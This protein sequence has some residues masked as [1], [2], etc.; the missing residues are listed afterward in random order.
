MPSNGKPVFGPERPPT[1]PASRPRDDLEDRVANSTSYAIG[2]S[3][4]SPDTPAIDTKGMSCIDFQIATKTPDATLEP[5]ILE[6]L[7]GVF[8]QDE[9]NWRKAH[10]ELECPTEEE[11][12]AQMKP[13]IP[14]K[15]RYFF[16]SSFQAQSLTLAYKAA[17][18]PT[19]VHF[20]EVWK[21]KKWAD[22]Q[23]DAPYEQTFAVRASTVFA[24]RAEGEVV[25]ILP[26][27]N[28]AEKTWSLTSLWNLELKILMEN[29]EVKNILRVDVDGNGSEMK[30]L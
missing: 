4:A 20:T 2:G 19:F 1:R 5:Y 18:F 17:N 27:G 25:V 30:A 26:K 16:Y 12:S 6:L 7:E 28:G 8:K 9:E 22:K 15:T 14:G 21:D 11:I 10:P 13:H 29:P 3:A 23:G 24:K